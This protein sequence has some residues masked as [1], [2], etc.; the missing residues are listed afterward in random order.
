M[1]STR[2]P[3]RRCTHPW[4]LDEGL[5]RVRILRPGD[6][7]RGDDRGHACGVQTDKSV[8]AQRSWGRVSAEELLRRRTF[9]VIEQQAIVRE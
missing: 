8:R 4:Y 7:A 9:D 5:D 1:R 6:C 3:E 2:L